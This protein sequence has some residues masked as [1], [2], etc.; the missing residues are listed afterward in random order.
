MIQ[1]LG[2]LR[3]RQISQ[4]TCT[5][6]IPGSG[7]INPAGKATVHVA[8][9]PERKGSLSTGKQ[10]W[11]LLSCASSGQAGRF[12][13]LMH[14]HNFLLR[15]TVKRMRTSEDHAVWPVTSHQVVAAGARRESCPFVGS[16]GWVSSGVGLRRVRRAMSSRR[17]TW[18]KVQ[19]EM[20]LAALEVCANLVSWV[21]PDVIS[22]AKD[23]GWPNPGKKS[24]EK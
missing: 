7:R 11:N 16:V 3:H 9:D 15:E 17:E 24:C 18:S 13:P 4:K 14:L 22:K 2:P 1:G 5:P 6:G 8:T 20:R 12:G 21:Y 10:P 19:K 23:A